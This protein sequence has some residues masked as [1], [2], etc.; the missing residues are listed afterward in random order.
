MTPRSVPPWLPAVCV[1][2]AVTATLVAVVWTSLGTIRNS[3]GNERAPIAPKVASVSPITS[4]DAPVATPSIV[5][6]APPPATPAVS[7]KPPALTGDAA[8][9]AFRTLP[10][11]DPETQ[12]SMILAMRESPTADLVRAAIRLWR[13]SREDRVRALLL[14]FLAGSRPAVA[15]A[16]R[17][18][19]LDVEAV[20]FLRDVV[21]RPADDATRPAILALSDLRK[22]EAARL[23]SLVVQ[24]PRDP[25]KSEEALA[26]LVVRPHRTA[27]QAL[28]N[29]AAGRA[30]QATKLRALRGLIS[31]IQ[32]W[33][34]EGADPELREAMGD[35]RRFV[36]TDGLGIASIAG[37]Q[38]GIPEVREEAAQIQTDIQSLR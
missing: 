33:D 37:T 34:K 2:S 18:T 12:A 20:P 8:E 24:D 9:E 28:E 15:D 21:L 13:T 17:D 22:D 7:P 5:P 6:D 10:T 26:A 32:T 4:P 16:E 30:S 3:S 35:A 31:M 27:V 38:S 23:L 36:T 25:E 14:F 1:G 19:I 11:A 29:L